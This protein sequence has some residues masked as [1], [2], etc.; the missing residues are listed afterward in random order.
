MSYHIIDEPNVKPLEKLI[1]NPLV[2]FF[3]AIFLPF[4]WDPPFFGRVWIP[5]VWILFNGYLLGSPSILKEAAI[6]VIGFGVWYKFFYGGAVALYFLGFG[7][8][9][10]AAVP[11][12][13]IL[14]QGVF[15]LLLYLLVFM[16]S[17]AYEIYNYTREQRR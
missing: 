7:H 14:K 11:Y 2:I 4:L 16:Q 12:L 9:L 5:L 17:P 13:L 3:V 15:F 8:Y 10:D 6:A 1:V